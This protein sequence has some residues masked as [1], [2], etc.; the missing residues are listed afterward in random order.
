MIY[1]ELHF[2][3]S[4]FFFASHRRRNAHP[5]MMLVMTQVLLCRWQEAPCATLHRL[6][7]V[8]GTLYINS[9]SCSN[10]PMK[11][12]LS[13][14]PFYKQGNWGSGS[15]SENLIANLAPVGAPNMCDIICAL[16]NIC[17]SCPSCPLSF[18]CFLTSMFCIL[19]SGMMVGFSPRCAGVTVRA[20]AISQALC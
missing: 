2:F 7:R 14:S 17:A 19:T 1:I 16:D 6:D 12:G 20:V 4:F 3:L 11:K 9:F 15:L 5:P 8:L 10:K 13:L 18:K